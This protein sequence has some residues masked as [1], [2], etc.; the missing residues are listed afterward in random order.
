MS[1]AEPR[2]P[3]YFLLLLVSLLFVLTAL[4][5]AVVPV[6]EDSATQ[7]GNPPPPSEFRATLRSDG[8]QWLLWE[9]AALMVFGM[10]SVGLDRLR[11]LQKER[12]AAKIPPVPQ[13][14]SSA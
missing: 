13:G 6:L 9:L 12:A 8:W 1:A 10:L 14:P 11:R 2:N 7:A 3:F 5:T 4:G